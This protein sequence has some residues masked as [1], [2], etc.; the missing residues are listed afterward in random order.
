MSATESMGWIAP[1]ELAERG[2]VFVARAR[3]TGP[4]GGV[5]ATV[6]VEE[7]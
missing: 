1:V 2:T 5:M 3:T 6:I 7:T 4:G